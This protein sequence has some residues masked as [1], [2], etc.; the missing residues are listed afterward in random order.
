MSYDDDF[1]D[2]F[3]DFDIFKLIRKSQSQMEDMLKKIESG[4][5]NGNWEIRQIDEPDMKGFA[6][7]GRFET[8][9]RTQ[10]FEPIEPLK[11]S[12]RRHLPEKP[13]EASKAALKEMREPL[14]DI[15]E[16]EN[17][18]R[19]YVELPGVEKE[20]IQL[21][22]GENHI[23]LRAKNFYKEIQLPHGHFSKN[24]STTQYKNGVL[25]IVL[26]KE[27]KLRPQDAKNLRTM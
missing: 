24:A 12:K 13:F 8:E 20:D 17:Q 27:N 6:I 14:V 10:P 23:E 3:D 1:K 11:P 21:D 26:P 19:L 4:E 16:E 15:F 22:I 25:E 18:I 9:E 7:R 2:L 5:I